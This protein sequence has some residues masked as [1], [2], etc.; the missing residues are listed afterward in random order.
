MDISMA[1]FWWVLA[2][3]AVAV[4]LATGTFYLLMIAL[5]LAAGAIA[6][7]LGLPVA[8]QTMVAAT[9]GGGATAAWHWHRSRQPA[10]PVAARNRDVNLDISDHVHVDAWTAEGTARVQHR[11][12][13]WAARLAP[14]AP[15]HPGEHVI[16]AV[17]GNWLVLAPI[18]KLQ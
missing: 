5:G 3:A 11:G 18:E 15:A 4:E 1:T 6:A 8:M 16:N 12:S 9:V 13:V 14:G 10:Q 7:H 17:E 2:G